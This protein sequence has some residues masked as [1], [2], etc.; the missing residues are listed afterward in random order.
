MNPIKEMNQKT[1]LL[2][3]WIITII[4]NN[5]KEFGSKQA[6]LK[7]HVNTKYDKIEKLKW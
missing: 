3:I 5:Q 2:G 4:H 1:E 7:E 6:I